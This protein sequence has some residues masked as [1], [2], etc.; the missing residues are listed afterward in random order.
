MWNNLWEAIQELKLARIVE[1]NLELARIAEL[2]FED[3]SDA[4]F[5]GVKAKGKPAE[6]V[7][8]YDVVL[9]SIKSDEDPQKK[10]ILRGKR[11][12]YMSLVYLYSEKWLES[13]AML[14]R[15]MEFSC[16]GEKI[17]ALMLKLQAML[18]V[19]EQIP[20]L[21]SMRLYEKHSDF[22]PEMQ[23]IPCKPVFYD[24]A[25]DHIEYPD[26]SAKLKGKGMLQSIK[27]WFGRG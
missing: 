15:C 1:R 2:K 25:L 26:L 27:G 22:P 6:I 20:D 17:Q 13:Y 11:A 10:A 21:G 3:E 5:R 14:Q 16:D 23:A 7:K 9:N 12:Y 8:V 19:N 24:L 4:V 18:S